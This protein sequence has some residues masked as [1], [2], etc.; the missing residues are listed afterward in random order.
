MMN[1]NKI[2]MQ[3]CARLKKETKG[4]L[5]CFSLTA[6]VAVTIVFVAVE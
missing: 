5:F 1:Q 4:C 2:H 6:Q 3:H